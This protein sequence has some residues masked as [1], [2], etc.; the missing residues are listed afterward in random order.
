MST[1]ISIEEPPR[2][3]GIVTKVYSGLLIIGFALLPAYLIAYLA[4]FQD[5]SL[6]FENHAI[7]RSRDRSGNA[8]GAVCHL[9]DLALLSVVG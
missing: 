2:I 1:T 8:R 4:F 6:K 5:P 7:P 9:C 3:I